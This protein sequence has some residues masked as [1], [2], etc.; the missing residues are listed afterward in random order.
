MLTVLEG[1]SFLVADDQGDVSGG[2]QGLYYNDTRYLSRWQ[3]T[4]NGERPQLLS[5]NTVDF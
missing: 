3:L 1:N 4:L 2:S 5:S